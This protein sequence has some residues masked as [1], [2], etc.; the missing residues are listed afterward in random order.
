MISINHFQS[1]LFSLILYNMQLKHIVVRH[2]TWKVREKKTAAVLSK[3]LTVEDVNNAIEYTKYARGSS[4]HNA[5]VNS[6]NTLLHAVD[7]VSRYV[8]HSNESTKQARRCIEAMQHVY[9]CPSFFLT[10]TP[11]DENHLLIQIYSNKIL[12]FNKLVRDMSNEEIQQ[13]SEHKLL[14]RIHFPGVCAFFFE[15][16]LDIIYKV[17]LNWDKNKNRPLSN[18]PT[19]FGKISAKM[20]TIEEQGRRSLHVHM[21]IWNSY[22]NKLRDDLFEPETTQRHR[23]AKQIVL[24][25]L[26][27]VCSTKCYFHDLAANASRQTICNTFPHECRSESDNICTLT[28]VENQQL[29]NLRL[30]KPDCDSV[31]FCQ[32]CN[33]TWSQKEI[34]TLYLQNFIQLRNAQDNFDVN[35]QRL[36]SMATEF[37]FLA[38]DTTIIPK[39]IID[40]AYNHHIHTTSCFKTKTCKD[41][42]SLVSGECRYRYPQL[43]KTVSTLEKTSELTYHWYKW[44]GELEH[45]P[46]YEIS[47]QRN[48]LD[49]FINASFPHIAYSKMCCNTNVALVLPG[50]I[51]QYLVNYTVKNTQKDD[52][53]QYELLK[54]AVQKVLAKFSEGD[55]EIQVAI[56]RLLSATYAHQSVNIVGAAMASYLTRN[57]SRFYFSHS[58]SWC[59]LNDNTVSAL[60]FNLSSKQPFFQCQAMHYICRPASLENVCAHDFFP[61]MKSKQLHQSHQM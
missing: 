54:D 30:K 44:S 15:L 49:V 7:A 3:Q 47:K 51:A 33:K 25:K 9:G 13:L 40:F 38:S 6:G 41:A 5:S 28:V 24:Q 21:L 19:V 56:K 31:L 1:E 34:V 20:A 37:Q 58:F 14:Q 50:L 35:I 59:P 36:K 32:L 11:D 53:A 17:A 4:T 8:P 45:R 16:M 43:P 61:N 52:V 18:E 39:Y 48:E 60:I 57:G 55:S 29:R 42:T 10:V 2:A 12:Q 23:S 46:I 22:F 27:E 26:D